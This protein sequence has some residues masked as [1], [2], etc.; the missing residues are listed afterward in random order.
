[1]RLNSKPSKD[2][3]EVQHR[4]SQFLIDGAL[5]QGRQETPFTERLLKMQSGSHPYLV[6]TGQVLL[7]NPISYLS[8]VPSYMVDLLESTQHLVREELDRDLAIAAGWSGFYT[9]FPYI[10]LQFTLEL[11]TNEDTARVQSDPELS[12]LWEL[13]SDVT[14]K[15]FVLLGGLSFME[16]DALGLLVMSK[17]TS[18][19]ILNAFCYKST[20]ALFGVGYEKEH[21][22]YLRAMENKLTRSIVSSE[23]CV[24][25]AFLQNVRTLSHCEIKFRL[26]YAANY[27]S[28][29]TPAVVT[30][31]SE[32]A[33]Q[34]S[35]S[36]EHLS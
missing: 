36:L 8:S 20:T 1:M 13:V 14:Y 34:R 6:R 9:R 29:P 35:L 22:D 4:I 7:H 23:D 16:N 3:I 30:L 33:L 24:F 11:A 17:A 25:N 27:C 26:K 15:S 21:F 32:P 5:L 19:E 31:L 2:T 18:N 28:L 12:L 10:F